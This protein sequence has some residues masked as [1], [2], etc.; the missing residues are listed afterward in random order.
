[1]HICIRNHFYAKIPPEVP[2]PDP[3]E[4]PQW[5]GEVWFRFP[6]AP[7]LFCTYLGQMITA[8]LKL[9]IIASD[10]T[11]QI[12]ENHKKRGK[13]SVEQVSVFYTKLIRWKIALPEPLQPNRIVTPYQ[14]QL[15]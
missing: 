11:Y 2:L 4:Y 3:L 14:L 6:S 12:F 1:M 5:Y 8:K 15:Q 9:W 7:T 10:I 13:L